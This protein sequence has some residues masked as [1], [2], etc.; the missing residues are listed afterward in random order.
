MLVLTLLQNIALLVTLAVLYEQ[1]LE[2]FSQRPVL[3]AWLS[4]L[5][6]GLVGIIGMM[7]PLNFAPGIIYDGRSIILFTAGYVGGPWGAAL[8]GIMTSVYR[9]FFVG[10]SGAAVGVLVI[11]QSAFTGA[12][13]YSIR[14][15]HSF[16]EHWPGILLTGYIV[17]IP[18]LLI[19]LLLPGGVG[20]RVLQEVGP[21][22]LLLY[23]VGQLLIISLFL[24]RRRA[25]ENQ[26]ILQDQSEWYQQIFEDSAIPRL[27]ID[28][29]SSRIADIN[30]AAEVFYGYSREEFCSLTIGDI[31]MHPQ[32]L[33]N[34]RMSLVVS[35]LNTAFEITHKTKDGQ[36]RNVTVFS[37]PVYARGKTLLNTI[38]IDTSKLKE[39]ERESYILSECVENAAIG[40]FRIDDDTGKILWANHEAC[41]RLGYTKAELQTM[42]VFDIDPNY[43]VDTWTDHRSTIKT[44]GGGTVET[45]HRCKDGSTYP[46]EITVTYFTY[47]GETLSFSFAKDIT[48]RKRSEQR[49]LE[50]LEQKDVLIQ[51]IHHRVR[52]NLSL[53]LGM[54]NLER[55]HLPDGDQHPGIMTRL[56]DR[57]LAIGLI[58]DLVYQDENLSKISL[59]A[60][61]LEVARNLRENHTLPAEVQPRITGSEVVLDVTRVMPIGLMVTEL[62]SHFYSAVHAQPPGSQGCTRGMEIV[63][64]HHSGGLMSVAFNSDCEVAEHACRTMR[65]DRLSI[66][67][68]TVLALQ[69][70]WEYHWS[71]AGHLLEITSVHL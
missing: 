62:F 19:Q 5:L 34:D 13:F 44:S 47:Q 18:M 27:V 35:K 39:L 10:G 53:I 9:Y 67:L 49:M 21:I 14:R 24:N 2:L 50:T 16:W 69:G 32:G 63:V 64:T 52:N 56:T 7:T 11:L 23:P 15:G 8:A 54:I 30:H 46:V 29:E 40:V 68:M 45:Q 33:I 60:L 37:S 51:E 6:F 17:H 31:S 43:T 71:T 55:N 57:I 28:P 66:E 42:F 36:P 12:V 20:F 4:G 59:N 26:Q 58:H 25:L 22:V 70:R 41:R 1:L 65:D 48:Q 3:S 38:V 61:I